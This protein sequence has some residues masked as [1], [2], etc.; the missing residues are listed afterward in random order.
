MSWYNVSRMSWY[1][2]A[3]GA[4]TIDN[5]TNIAIVRLIAVGAYGGTPGRNALRPYGM[6]A[7]YLKIRMF[8]LPRI[9]ESIRDYLHL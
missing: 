4:P 9:F 7:V 1:R 3:S 6:W 2:T 8:F 5:C